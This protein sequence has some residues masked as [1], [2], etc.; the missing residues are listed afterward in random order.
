[1]VRELADYPKVKG[2]TIDRL[3][4]SGKMPGFKVG[5][6]WRFRRAAI[7]RWT[8]ANAVDPGETGKRV[9]DER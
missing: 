8:D 4:G 2:R 7:D 5:G 1:M 9:T 6:S 3:A